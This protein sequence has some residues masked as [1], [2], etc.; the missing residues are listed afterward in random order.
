[1]L[2]RLAPWILSLTLLVVL[3]GTVLAGS[4]GPYDMINWDRGRDSGNFNN[5]SGVN[6]LEWDGYACRD[7]INNGTNDW[8]DIK[9]WRH[10]GIFPPQSIGIKRVYC[11]YSNYRIWGGITGPE[12]FHFQVVDFSGGGGD[13]RIDARPYEVKWY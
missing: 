2:K 4:Y 10:Q 1:M 13:N 7:E 12:W 11:Y 6:N 8:V 9:M 5:G 3:T